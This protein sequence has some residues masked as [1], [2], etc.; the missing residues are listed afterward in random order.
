MF[1]QTRRTRI[2]AAAAIASLIGLTAAC[3]SSG[4]AESDSTDPGSISGDITVLTWRTDLVEDGTF[5][6][7]K[8]AFEKAYPDVT[9]EFEGI[10]DY[11]GEVRTRMN[12]KEYG[13]VLGIPNTVTPAQL[14]DFFEPLGKVD[15]LEKTYRFLRDKT[16]DGVSYGIPVVGNTQGIV[17]NKTV[18]EAAGITEVPTTS[19]EFLA[20]L[21]LVKA[22][23]AI[24][25]YTNYKDG[26]PLTQWESH[27]GSISAD[28]EYQNKM[29]VSDAPWADGSDHFV[30]DSLLWDAVNQGYTEA[31]PTS[32]NWEESKALLATGE[33]S[34]MAL[35]SWAISQMQQAAT[36]A[37]KDPAEIGYMP[38]PHQTDG[39][40]YATVGGDYNQAINVNSEHKA[41]ARAW[42]DWFNAESGFAEAQG[43]LSPLKDGPTPST[44]VDFETLGVEY[45]AQNPGVPGEESLLNDID[46][47]AEIGLFAP[48]YRQRLVDSARGAT[49]ETK[50]Q[51]FAD[52][53][54]RWAAARASIG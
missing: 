21:A 51:I 7:Y 12:T 24:P 54:A 30:I 25:L 2:V 13:D 52:L 19:E 34:A 33:I 20:D 35:G 6:G 15:E 45:V 28:P 47:E 44:L 1:P 22:T 16:Y 36:D 3:S 40:F 49:D 27:R 37:G 29:T 39:Q 8:A 48:E 46:N 14:P 38:F 31:D 9:V 5:D 32:T 41:A 53:N 42:I 18:W 4:E 17:Y 10:T 23:G 50:E 43:G 26:W 11:E